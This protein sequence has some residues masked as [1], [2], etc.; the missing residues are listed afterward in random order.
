MILSIPGTL[1]TNAFESVYMIGTINRGPMYGYTGTYHILVL[2]TCSVAKYFPGVF[3]RSGPKN[4]CGRV[5]KNHNFRKQDMESFFLLFLS[6]G[7]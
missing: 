1:F 2:V 5:K 7:K 3:A 4:F 6:K